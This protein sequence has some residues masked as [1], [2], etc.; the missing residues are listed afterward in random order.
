MVERG[1]ITDL[2][3]QICKDSKFKLEYHRAAHLA[4]G[5]LN[6]HALDVLA[7]IGD[8]KTMI[9]IAEGN[10]PVCHKEKP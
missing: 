8:L 6:I 5:V 1:T 9:K 3:V 4:A 7:A 2:Y 10:H